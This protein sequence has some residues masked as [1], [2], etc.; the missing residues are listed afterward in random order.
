MDEIHA[1][2]FDFLPIKHNVLLGIENL[3]N[4][5]NSA[6]PAVMPVETN[7]NGKLMI[8]WREIMPNP[9]QPRD[10]FPPEEMTRLKENIRE[11]GVDKPIKIMKLPESVG[12]VH[13][14]I[15]DGES[16]WQGCKDL[17]KDVWCVIVPYIA[18]ADELYLAALNA[19]FPQ[20]PHTVTENIKSIRRLDKMHKTI[21]EMCTI[22]GR[23]QPWVSMYKR[24]VKLDPRV[25]ELLRSDRPEEE[26]LPATHAS[27]LA[28][29]P[30]EQ[31]LGLAEMIIAGGLS[32]AHVKNL[33]RRSQI[34]RSVPVKHRRPREEFKSVLTAVKRTN[35]HLSI[36]NAQKKEIERMV[37]TR[38]TKDVKKMLEE[39]ADCKSQIESLERELKKFV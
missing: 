28:D 6:Y 35:E 5:M 1:D 29:L 32:L 9:D 4:H 21:E 27:V 23:S 14:M 12:T 19:N 18:D 13:Y 33:V 34:D 31:Q 10:Y 30:P 7:H 36:I 3:M 24:I 25:Q 15:V 26:R 37:I 17:N 11:Y 20:T 38:D 2:K 22:L 16:R 39:L 8:P